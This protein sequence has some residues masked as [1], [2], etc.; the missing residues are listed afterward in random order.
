[1]FVAALFA[2]EYLVRTYSEIRVNARQDLARDTQIS[3]D[4]LERRR[5]RKFAVECDMASLDVVAEESV[6]QQ[7]QDL[8]LAA[9]AKVRKTI[10]LHFS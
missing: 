8:R 2:K 4:T 1:M 3:F 10:Q 6:S 9:A 7:Q 5:R